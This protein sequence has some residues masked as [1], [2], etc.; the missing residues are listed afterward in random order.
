MFDMI[1][2]FVA[3][4]FFLTIDDLFATTFP[5]SVITN[6]KDLNKSKILVMSK[7]TNTSRLVCKRYCTCK[8]FFSPSYLAMTIVDLIINVW[9]FLIT[10]FQILIFN[11]YAPIVCMLLQIIGY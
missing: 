4:G 5:K 6:V 2:Q 8:N 11:Y 3:I 7:D 10:N 1:K 9:Y